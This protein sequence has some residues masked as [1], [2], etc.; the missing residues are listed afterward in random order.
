M[1]SG[2]QQPSGEVETSPRIGQHRSGMST[3][4]EASPFRPSVR[5]ASSRSDL[6]ALGRASPACYSSCPAEA[7]GTNVGAPSILNLLARKSC[8]G[9][10][11]VKTTR[12]CSLIITALFLRKPTDSCLLSHQHSSEP[13]AR[14]ATAEDSRPAPHSD[15]KPPDLLHSLLADE[16]DARECL[17]HSTMR[18]NAVFANRTSRVTRCSSERRSSRR[19]SRS[20]APGMMSRTHRAL[21]PFSRAR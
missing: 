1:S 11:F 6:Y 20:P 8:S 19:I 7:T 5:R 9:R 21:C 15:A 13:P 17:L 12:S 4:R 10:S 18:A 16:H 3:P 2:P 14:R